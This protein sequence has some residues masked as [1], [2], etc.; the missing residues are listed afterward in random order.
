MSPAIDQ[1]R[2]RFVL[3]PEAV[4]LQINLL[5]QKVGELEDIALD[6][7]IAHMNDESIDEK[8][9]VE[10]WKDVRIEFKNTLNVIYDHQKIP[11]ES[12]EQAI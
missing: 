7:S 10:I 6:I 9:F 12:E 2:D 1:L 8:A 11:D 4:Q 3:L 5:I